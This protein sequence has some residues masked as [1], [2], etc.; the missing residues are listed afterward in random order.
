MN[1]KIKPALRKTLRGLALWLVL[2]LALPAGLSPAAHARQEL[3]SG[4]YAP[5]AFAKSSPTDLS[6]GQ[7]PSV[8]LQWTASPDA[9][10]YQVC[11]DQDTNKICGSGWVDV[12]NVTSVTRSTPLGNTTY[13]WQVSAT[14]AT[15]TTYADGASNVFW[16][17]T[18]GAAPGNFTKSLPA[19]GATGQPIT[20]NLT[21]AASSGATSYEYCLDKDSNT[22]CE[23]TWI[24]V[25][26]VLT[27]GVGPL[28][29]SSTY[30]WHVRAKNDAGFIFY[31]GNNNTAA[32]RTFTTVGPPAAFGKATPVDTAT[33][34]AVSLNLTWGAST[35]A[36]SY[37]YCYDITP[38]NACSSWSSTAGTSAP[39]SG[40]SPGTTYYWQVRAVNSVSTT[41]A[42]GADIAYWAFTT[43]LAP[44]GFNKTA[45][46]PGATNQLPTL[47][48]TWNASA[49]AASY[50]Y[51]IDA[52]TNNA[53]NTGWINAGTNLSVV[54]PGLAAG[55]TYSWHVR[56]I[57]A[58]G[59]T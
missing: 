8:T 51:C 46:T 23:S 17:L 20:L 32:F 58:F 28:D 31:S 13:S 50:E 36:T 33:G 5:A 34:Q 15:G 59:T 57:N 49:G 3:A 1:G 22:T 10:S 41:Y 25:G 27:I 35:D 2:V 21:W 38:D 26:N 19:N 37:E 55:Q 48:L 7:P 18:T 45:P 42:D 29:A 54:P 52:D 47:S 24:N 43:G 4:A 9:D 6:T 11:F 16:S 40:L 39:I 14:N 56:A 53:C 30:S 12:G 44:G